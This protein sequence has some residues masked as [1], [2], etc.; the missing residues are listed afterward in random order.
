MFVTEAQIIM[1]DP[2]PPTPKND[3][4]VYKH[5]IVTVIGV[6]VALIFLFALFRQ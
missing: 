3:Q 6:I 2:K 5:G 4:R 1:S